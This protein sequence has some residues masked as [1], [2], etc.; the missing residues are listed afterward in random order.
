MFR[1]NKLLTDKNDIGSN[2][3]IVMGQLYGSS[4]NLAITELL[5]G[6]GLS[7]IICPNS[8][9]VYSTFRDIHFF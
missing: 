1:N 8:D 9:S 7:I 4:K 6:N 3:H 5:D 2:G